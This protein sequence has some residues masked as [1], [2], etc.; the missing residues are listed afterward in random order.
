MIGLC[1]GEDTFVASQPVGI[2]CFWINVE[3]TFFSKLYTAPLFFLIPTPYPVKSPLFR[4]CPV[5]S[6]FYLHVQQSNKNT[7]TQWAVNSL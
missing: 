7:R 4:W 2:T 3:I 6:R 1:Q 5:L